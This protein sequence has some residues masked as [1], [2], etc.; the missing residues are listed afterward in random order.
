MLTVWCAKKIPNSNHIRTVQEVK[1]SEYTLCHRN[2]NC[3]PII[4]VFYHSIIPVYKF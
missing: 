3:Y 4:V 2:M 1:R